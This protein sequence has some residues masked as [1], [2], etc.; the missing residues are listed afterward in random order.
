MSSNFGKMLQISIFGES[1]GPVV[2]VNIDGLPAGRD[3]D[4]DYICT[5]MAR[6]APGSDPTATMRREKDTPIIK[7]GCYRGKTTGAP[8]MAVIENSDIHDSDYDNTELVPRPSHADYPAYVK[9]GGHNDIRG[10]GH[11]SGRL[12][13]GLVFAG[14]VCR[15]IMKEHDITVGGH[16]YSVGGAYDEK[17]DPC[18]V[19]KFLLEKLSSEYF[20][21]IN[22]DIRADMREII[23]LSKENLD[24]VGGIVEVA[25]CGL[26]AG[27]GSPMFRGVE[28]VISQ[29]VFGVPAVKGIEFGAGFS[30]ACMAGSAANDQYKMSHNRVMTT[31]NNNGGILGGLTTGMP[32]IFRAV[33]KPTPSISVEQNSVNL[34]TMQNTKLTVKGRHDPCIVPRALPVI[35]SAASIAL[36]DLLLEDGLLK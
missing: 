7:S 2:G 26:P 29:A 27:I 20:A 4:M 15:S 25:V 17:F 5:Q 36:F 13:A 1:H 18:G 14:A 28:S 34:S 12:T 35:E 21:V 22:E 23:A 6:R 8:L 11:F 31:T 32:L 9:F 30:F 16:V 3:V 33:V 24:S 19:D 10:G